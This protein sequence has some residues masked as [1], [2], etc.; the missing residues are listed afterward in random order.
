MPIGEDIPMLIPISIVLV[1]FLVFVL[2]LFANF[3]EQHDIVKMSQSSLTTGSYL[4]N[5]KFG[6]RT[7]M[8]D[9]SKLGY[10]F[11]VCR[12]ISQL[13]ISSSYQMRINIS[14]TTSGKNWCWDNT[15]SY[16]KEP[17]TSV[18][19]NFPVLFLNDTT[20]EFGQVKISVSK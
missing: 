13:N 14:D 15:N 2:S 6:T 3:S 5:V 9:I 4:I 8:L 20:T 16:S 10:N 12:D 17:T 7:G 19:N 1:I 11:T 18:S